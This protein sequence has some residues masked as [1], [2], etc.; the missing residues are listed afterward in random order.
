MA[1]SPS[2]GESGDAPPPPR[3]EPSIRAHGDTWRGSWRG[4]MFVTPPRLAVQWRAPPEVQV[5]VY[6]NAELDP[7]PPYPS[8]SSVHGRS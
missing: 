4:V 1:T 8:A 5:G 6:W 3:S 2:S 7:C